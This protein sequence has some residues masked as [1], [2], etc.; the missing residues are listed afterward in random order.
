MV[1]VGQ[2]VQALVDTASDLNLIRKDIAN[3]LR[4]RSFFPARAA[5]QAGGIPLKIYSV[6]HERLQITDSFGAHLDARDPLTSAN[7]K[8]TLIMGLPWLLH[9]NLILNFDLMTIK[10]RDSSSTVTDSIEES[11]DLGS[12]IQISADFQVMQV[13]LETLNE[14]LE[15]PTIPKAYRDLADV[16]SPSNANSLPPHRDEDHAIELEPG[17]TPPFGP[18]YNL[19]EYQL[20]TLREYID[21]NLANGFIRPSK[22][23]AGAPVLFTPKSDGTLRLCVDYRG[24]NSM[25]IKN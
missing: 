1:L 3:H 16:F 6:F 17:K 12:P 14:S 9:H 8:A 25:T 2:E 19:S 21:E 23:S 11:L 18:L 13:Q 24:L 10:W 5:T 15:E 7:I 20:K 22:S 4:L